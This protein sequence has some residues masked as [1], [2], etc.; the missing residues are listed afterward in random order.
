MNNFYIDK[1]DD[2]EEQDANLDKPPK[3]PAI[4]TDEI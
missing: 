3:P 2:N 4:S 1:P